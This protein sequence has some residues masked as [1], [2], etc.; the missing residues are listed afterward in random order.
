MTEI[1]GKLQSFP[2]PPEDSKD[3]TDKLYHEYAQNF[4]KSLTK[5]LPNDIPSPDT[6]SSLL[7]R[8]DPSRHSLSYLLV[9]HHQIIGLSDKPKDAVPDDFYPGSAL[10]RRAC[11]FLG[12]FDP[13]QV[14][15]AGNQWRS[16]VELL[17]KA[18]ESAN[19]P[20][21]AIRPIRDAML[22]LDPTGATF[23]STH[24]ILTRL[25]LLARAYSLSLPVLDKDVFFFPTHTDH[26]FL[27][28]S[29][30]IPCASHEI[31][32]NYITV[33]SGLTRS[34][35]HREYLK[36]FLYGG[37]IYGALKEWGKALHFLTI[38]ISAPSVNTVSLIMV[39]AY[40][41]WVLFQLL[42]KGDVPPLP[43][44]VSPHAA[45]LY[46]SLA[47]PYD[48]LADAFKAGDYNALKVEAEVGQSVWQMDN[49]T[50]L[51]LQ[52]LRAFQKHS[53]LKL[54]S[55]FAALTMADIANRTHL[56]AG[57]LE[58]VERSVVT[59][60]TQGELNATLL[61]S[62]QGSESTMVRF[63]T[64]HTKPTAD[65]EDTL[66]QR[67]AEEREKL[68]NLAKNVQGSDYRM[69]LGTEYID[70]LRRNQKKRERAARDG[71]ASAGKVTDFDSD[72]DMMSDL[73]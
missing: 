47:R 27:Q 54:G 56:A 11:L 58:E 69:E 20:L 22:R 66:R 9:F 53:V 59:L 7:D 55:T 50:G 18:A 64:A 28:R 6:A 63:W 14:R 8:L 25:C 65:L 12:A 57:N 15:Y 60:V 29:E 3:L 32:A 21:V 45:K 1:Q 30:P 46:K 67:L 43:K 61:H 24:V 19:K 34:F 26:T 41:K 35:G 39:E 71:G 42:D 52:V 37:M 10:W 51:V 62:T 68:H 23:T 49:N 44:A 38:A 48:A 40:K 5:S 33:S 36:Y 73:R 17:A 13:V 72:E 2:P 4:V 70:Y 31:S 16:V